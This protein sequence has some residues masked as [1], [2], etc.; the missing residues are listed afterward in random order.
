MSIK[1]LHREIMLSAAYQLGTE[2][3]AAA[4]EKDPDNRLYWRGNERRM[5]AE[6]LRDSV[7][8]VAGSLDDS[9]GGPSA[10]LTSTFTRRTIYGTVSRYLVNSYLQSFDFPNPMASAEKRFTSTVPLQR[11]FLMNSDFIQLR[12]EEVAKAADDQTDKRARIYKIYNL[13]FGRIPSEQEVARGLD[14]I[15]T[16]QSKSDKE[17]QEKAVAA[18]QG[19]SPQAGGGQ[20]ADR[21]SGAWG[22]QGRSKPKAGGFDADSAGLEYE[23]TVWGRYVKVLLGSTEFTYI[24]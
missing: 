13:V 8:A 24:N 14:F 10:E 18:A 9:I 7:L 2:S 19:T 16:E 22:A 17:G 21:T 1:K 6:Q 4:A 11:L 20:M 23:P 12:A 15:R 5:T 3:Y